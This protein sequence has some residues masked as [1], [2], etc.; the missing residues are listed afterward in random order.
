MSRAPTQ[1][2][3][4]IVLEFVQDF[5]FVSDLCCAFPEIDDIFSGVLAAKT[6][7]DTS[8][9]SLS[10]KFI[11]HILQHIPVINIAEVT[12]LASGRYAKSTVSAYALASR[13]VS[14][15]IQNLISSLPDRPRDMTTPQVGEAFAALYSHELD[16]YVTGPERWGRSF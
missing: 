2:D 15:A 8:T 9:R 14:R 7:G 5:F 4:Q 11:F 3:N 16:A 10:R 13:V 1:H 6:R 12:V